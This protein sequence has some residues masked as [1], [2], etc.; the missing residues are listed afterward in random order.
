MNVSES[1]SELILDLLS[2]DG[3]L[4]TQNATTLGSTRVKELTGVVENGRTFRNV[5]VQPENSA[6]IVQSPR[7]QGHAKSETISTVAVKGMVL[8]VHDTYSTIKRMPARM[9]IT[10]S[11]DKT[12]NQSLDHLVNHSLRRIEEVLPTS[13]D[14]W[15]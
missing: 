4:P 7:K 10:A 3:W 8:S 14:F 5:T 6:P 15:I 13:N 11:K 12:D 2:L 9:E 1:R